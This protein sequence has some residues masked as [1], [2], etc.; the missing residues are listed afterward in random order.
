M[1]KLRVDKIASVGVSTET[2][3]SVFFDGSGDYLS[4][5][6]SDDFAY[7]TGDFTWE[8]WIYVNSFSG[9]RYLLDHGSNGG[10][11]S[12]GGSS[13][14]TF[15]YYNTT[16]GTG[17][18]LHSTGFGTLST[19]LSSPGW[20][21]VIPMGLSVCAGVGELER[22]PIAAIICLPVLSAKIFSPS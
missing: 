11:I 20:N 16:T 18:A 22:S 3:G 6:S 2:T 13:N 15:K 7:G 5:A 4:L 10:T 8:L 17:T 1:A 12:N 14:T 9:N 21:V 19:S